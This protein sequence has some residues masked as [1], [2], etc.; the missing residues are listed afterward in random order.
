VFVTSSLVSVSEMLRRG[1]GELNFN[2]RTRLEG[3]KTKHERTEFCPLFAN[4]QST[5]EAV[6]KAVQNEYN[7][8]PER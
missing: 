2:S 7:N 1:G 5:C 8:A 3:S 6:Q 4:D